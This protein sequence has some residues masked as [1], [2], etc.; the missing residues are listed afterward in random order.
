MGLHC[1]R[2]HAIG[3]QFSRPVAWTIFVVQLIGSAALS[4]VKGTRSVDYGGEH[5]GRLPSLS[6]LTTEILYIQ[7]FPHY[8]LI[9]TRVVAQS[10]KS[11]FVSVALH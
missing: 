2:P 8:V 3:R 7:L 5:F 10:C 4:T 1:C 6:V 9:D 11:Y